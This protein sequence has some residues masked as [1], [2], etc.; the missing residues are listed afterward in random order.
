MIRAIK[1]IFIIA[2]FLSFVTP[3]MAATYYVSNKG[4]DNN[5]GTQTSPWARCPGMDGW[6]G[7]A[8]LKPADKVYFDSAGTW[9][10]NG[11]SQGLWVEGGVTYIG[12]SWGNGQR[13]KFDTT[14]S[15]SR[16]VVLIA[17]DHDTIETEFIGFE[18]D[19]NMKE[20]RGVAINNGIQKGLLTVGAM[21]RIKNC[22]VH[23]I[24]NS[25]YSYGIHV[26]VTTN[27]TVRNVEILDCIV[28][29][30]PRS[31]V[32]L[33]AGY[34]SDNAHIYNTT[35]RGCDISRSHLNT[36][37]GGAGILLKNHVENI[38]VE[39]NKL[40][41]N[42]S[43]IHVERT[44]SGALPPKNIKI[45]YNKI[46]S[47]DSN[48][49]YVQ[50][51]P[52]NN[53]YIYCNL[54]YKN[55]KAGIKFESN[56]SGT[57][58]YHIF[59]NTF[60]SNRENELVVRGSGAKFQ[61]LEIKNNIFYASGANCISDSNGRITSHSNNLFYREGNSGSLA[62]VGGRTYYSNNINDWESTAVT[63]LPG[64]VNVANYEFSLSEGS[65]AKNLGADLSGIFSDGLNSN[66]SWPNNV[67]TMQ[68]GSDQWAIGAFVYGESSTADKVAAPKNLRITNN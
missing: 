62:S 18:V 67:Q 19:V 50:A 6:S 39:N 29:D 68:W 1:T 26:S 46:S 55:A 12:D 17:E 28:H 45:R 56:L 41:N 21:K 15:Y 44:Y 16:A 61:T 66:S 7:G 13:A 38:V 47:G 60:Y 14:G 36:S 25:S 9:T 23:H 2:I 10:L 53:I 27:C 54:I 59:N 64:F 8:T 63:G 34:T 3:A 5:P 42:N 65:V 35:I 30:T 43:G 4:N 11:G 57:L 51:G 32:C 22:Y 31:A 52:S 49:I 37:S 48:G 40:Y 58:S 33:Y 20:S 24:G